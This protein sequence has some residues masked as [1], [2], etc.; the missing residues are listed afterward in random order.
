MWFYRCVCV[1]D[2]NKYFWIRFIKFP[3]THA[4]PGNLMN[5]LETLCRIARASLCGSRIFVPWMLLIFSIEFPQTHPRPRN[6]WSRLEIV[7]R[8][9]RARV[10][11]VQEYLF[12]FL[13]IFCIE[14]PQTFPRPRN[15]MKQV[16]KVLSPLAGQSL[17]F[18]NMSVDC[19]IFLHGN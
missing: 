19:V 5:R 15:R 18:R 3:K 17:L 8:L 14:F 13:L 2:E 10:F 1:S 12:E 16:G 9:A 4:L 11:I 7:C 6:G